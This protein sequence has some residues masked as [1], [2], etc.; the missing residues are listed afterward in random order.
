MEE[1]SEISFKDFIEENNLKEFCFLFGNGFLLSHTDVLIHKAFKISLKECQSILK[2]SWTDI[3]KKINASQTDI[4]PEDLLNYIRTFYG[5]NVFIKYLE[6]QDGLTTTYFDRPTKFLSK[7]KSIY[8]LNY[9]AFSYACIQGNP[10]II[11]GFA[12]DKYISTE[13]IKE[14]ITNNKNNKIP[15]YFL[16]G[17]FLILT[18][19]STE[20][21][22]LHYKKIKSMNGNLSQTIQLE[23]KDLKTQYQNAMLDPSARPPEEDLLLVFSDRHDHKH[24]SI[25]N[26]PYLSFCLGQF[27]NEQKIFSFGCSFKRDQHLFEAL[28]ENDSKNPKTF[29]I[30]YYLDEEKD[31]ITKSLQNNNLPQKIYIT[32]VKLNDDS[33][34]KYIW[35]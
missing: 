14:R 34:K 18:K 13:K 20:S 25:K 12:G 27:K 33:I 6:K 28:L 23:Y 8:T 17:S 15:F 21:Q 9:D 16:H 10:E 30:G 35:A 19:T 32:F 5:A 24:T 7:F 31:Y 3:N 4:C 2:T 22:D 29:Y 26:D 1:I 11:D